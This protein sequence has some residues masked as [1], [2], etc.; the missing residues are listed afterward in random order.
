MGYRVALEAII[1]SALV[2]W[3]GLLF[4]VISASAPTGHYLVRN[5]DPR[6]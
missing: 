3:F 6:L 1:E 5:I 2:T 4:Y